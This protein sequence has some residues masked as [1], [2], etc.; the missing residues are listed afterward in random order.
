MLLAIVF[1]CPFTFLNM[2]EKTETAT[3]VETQYVV[4]DADLS[5]EKAGTFHD[6]QDMQ[7]LGKQQELRV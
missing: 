1:H 4:A 5:P 2:A 6:R 3:Y 7:R